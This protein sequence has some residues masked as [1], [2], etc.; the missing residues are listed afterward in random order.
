MLLGTQTRSTRIASPCP[1]RPDHQREAFYVSNA[2]SLAAP[3][4][5]FD[6]NLLMGISHD[7]V[8]AIAERHW[9]SHDSD[10]TVHTTPLGDSGLYSAAL[11]DDSGRPEAGAATLIGPDGRIWVLSSNPGIHDY[12]LAVSL[13]QDAYK[14]GHV[15]YLDTELFA[16]RVG[17][18]TWD[19]WEARRAFLADLRA[20]SLRAKSDRQLP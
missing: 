7:E 5:P 4:A 17:E 16:A 13:L 1:N 9:A 18:L 15:D 6:D 20:G 2:P 12:D 3:R 8:V 10:C 11:V 14:S 19:R